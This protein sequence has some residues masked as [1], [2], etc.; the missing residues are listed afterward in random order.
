MQLKGVCRAIRRK[1]YNQLWQRHVC[2]ACL[3]PRVDAFQCNNP[4]CSHHLCSQ[5]F[6]A[7]TDQ[8]AEERCQDL[9]RLRR[10]ACLSCFFCRAGTMPSDIARQMQ[11]VDVDSFLRA[12]EV[13]AQSEKSSEMAAERA[14]ELASYR[15]LSASEKLFR[16]EKEIIGEIIAIKCPRC[17]RKYADFDACAALTCHCGA[18]FCAL[19]NAGPFNDDE[20]CHAHVESCPDRPA[21]MTDSLFVEN[22]IWRSHVADR[23]QRQVRQYLASSDLTEDLKK[24]LL[25]FFS[26]P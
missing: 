6:A 11:P 16:I 20:S 24:R 26:A 25:A 22:A 14:R 4:E 23:Q 9:E 8:T 3:E 13:H 2:G 19:C 15:G 10:V 17:T 18:H 1:N 21:G 5:C 12:V 7:A